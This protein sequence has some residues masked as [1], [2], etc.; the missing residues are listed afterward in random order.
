MPE[1]EAKYIIRL[2]MFDRG[3]WVRDPEPRHRNCCFT[4]KDNEEAMR[5]AELYKSEARKKNLVISVTMDSLVEKRAVKLEAVVEQSLS[6]PLPKQVRFDEQLEHLVDEEGVKYGGRR[7]S[8]VSAFSNR[9]STKKYAEEKALFNAVTL[10]KNKGAD[11]Y[12]VLNTRIDDSNQ[13]YDATP[14]TATVTALLYK[15]S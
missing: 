8:L 12:E 14:Y 3:A 10:A 7:F 4:A 9:Q 6:V 13:E 1:Y 2:H 11:A 5:R 15:N